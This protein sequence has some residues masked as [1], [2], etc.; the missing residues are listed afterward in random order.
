MFYH[1]SCTH[2]FA[3][4]SV[5]AF[6]KYGDIYAT[7]PREKSKFFE[8]F[9]AEQMLSPTGTHVSPALRQAVLDSM[10]QS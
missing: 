8:H 10:L 5:L 9:K 7:A 2:L 4:H 1:T 6:D 3:T